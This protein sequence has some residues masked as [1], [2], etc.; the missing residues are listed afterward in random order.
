MSKIITENFTSGFYEIETTNK[1]DYQIKISNRFSKIKPVEFI[2]TI[3][4]I[5]DLITILKKETKSEKTKKPKYILIDSDEILTKD[6][7]ITIIQEKIFNEELHEYKII[8]REDF[9]EDLMRWIGEGSED[10]QLMLDDLKLLMSIT[11][12]YIFSSVSTNDYI[13]QGCSEFDST[14]K[15]LIELNKAIS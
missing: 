9:L 14:C 7:G 13:Y 2:L 15:E 3:H 8:D 5:A 1:F 6:D 10:K 11:D 4:E 12:D